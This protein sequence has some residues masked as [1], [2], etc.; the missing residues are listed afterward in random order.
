M[1]LSIS[2]D[3]VYTDSEF[4]DVRLEGGRVGSAEFQDC[5]FVDCNF[6]ESVFQNCRFAG[7]LFRGCDLTLVNVEGSAFSS[8]RFERCTAAGV[9]WTRAAW[10]AVLLGKPLSF[11]ECAL[12]HATFIDLKL[13][14]IKVRDC[15]AVDVD[16]R[17]A[18]LTRADFSGTDLSKSLFGDTDLTEADLSHAR[19][20]DI[21]PGRNT[22]K[23]TRFSLPEAMSL[24]HSLD[25]V[26]GMGIAHVGA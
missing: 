15:A 9:N 12:N 16:F 23:Q 13:Q 3:T 10:P 1:S 22:L 8:V 19:N 5:T 24:L 20:Y 26:L 4:K 6:V 21:D 7:C 17:A 2:S 25:I 11:S 18:D 14:G